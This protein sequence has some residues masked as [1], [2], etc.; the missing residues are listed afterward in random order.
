MEARHNQ[1]ITLLKDGSCIV[2][3][4]CIQTGKMYSVRVRQLNLFRWLNEEEPIQIAL[5]D[6]NPED[7]EFLIS[8]I[9]PEGW[10]QLFNG[11]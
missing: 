11:K 6:V 4:K 8:G 1:T 9:S 2:K 7:R 3:G 5:S 10:N